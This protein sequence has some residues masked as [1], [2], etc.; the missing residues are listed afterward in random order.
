LSELH[1]TAEVAVFFDFCSMY[2]KC[3]GADGAPGARVR[4]L[5]FADGEAGAVG[6]FPSEDALFKQ[7]L[8]S[9]GTFYS[10]PSTQV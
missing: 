1:D 2:Q 10:H 7:A 8:G 9:L 3:C 5:G 6:R 4:V